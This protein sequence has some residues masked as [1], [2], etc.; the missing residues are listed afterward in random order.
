[1]D[2]LT[3]LRVFRRAAEEGSFAAAA[4]RLG[5]SAAAVSKNI[6]E[7]E[8]HLSA[9]LFHRTTRRMSLTEAGSR[10]Y[11]QVLR[12][13]DDLEQA[14]RSLSPQQRPTGVLRVAAPLT[15]TLTR[16]SRALPEFLARHPEL[17]LE[18]DLD[19]RRV[20]IVKDGFDLAIRGSDRLEDS[21]LVAR[22]LTTLSH[23]VCGAPSY[24]ARAGVPATPDDLRRHD[25][26][27][28]T[29]SGHAN[30][31]EFR[32]AG[33]SVRVPVVSRYRVS[34][35]LAV[36]DALLAGFGLSLIPLAYVEHDLQHGRL[37]T[38][39]DD[40]AKVETSIYAVYPSRRHIAAKTRVFI[41]FLIEQL[42]PEAGP[43][44]G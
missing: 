36:R 34:S 25:C 41:D 28:Y 17:S 21:S 8:A 40:W 13:L 35:S 2:Q 3:A 11:E 27:Q 6:G 19:D 23:V 15:V 7:L 12:I 4:R 10:Y 31:W 26:V 1:M 42:R 39:L 33:R 38:V 37:Q 5:L 20:D 22:K 16:L 44:A 24:F 29:L 43:A 32:Q 30:E 18:L 14:D 9:R